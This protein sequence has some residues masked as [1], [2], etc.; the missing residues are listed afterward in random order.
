MVETYK[1]EPLTPEEISHWDEVTAVY[2]NRE[3][4]HRQA[5]LD[6]L[7]DSR[8]VEVRYWGIRSSGE[9]VG[10]FCGGVL[11]KG[12]FKILGSPLKGWGT[13]FLGPVHHDGFETKAFLRS[14]DELVRDEGFAMVE[15]EGR[16]L[17]PAVMESANYVG[18]DQQTYMVGL[19]PSDP[20]LMWKQIDRKTRSQV[21]K[22]N[23][24]GL[25][26]EDANGS[27]FVEEFFDQ[28]VEVLARKNLYPPYTRACAS[29]L[30]NHLQP[31][32]L[33][34]ALQ[35]RDATGR[36]IATGLLPHDGKAVYLWGAASRIDGWRFCPNDLLQWAVMERAARE[37]LAEYN[38]CGYGYFKSKFGGTLQHHKRWHKCYSGSARWARKGY[39]V[40]FKNRVRLRGRWENVT[41]R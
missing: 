23:R 3:L 31:C 36:V 29:L 21:R 18:V 10:Y 35:V 26:V 8:G 7:A 41:R 40:Y 6:Y 14:L 28:F 24:V 19:T 5:W 30:L 1:L 11:R 39:E 38:M 25:V 20:E 17:E 9:T 13:N 4:F 32:G 16:G 27:H 37:G 2:P 33:L 15:I 22:A 34:F 12:P